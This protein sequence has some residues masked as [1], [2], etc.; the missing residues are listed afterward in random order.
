M[1]RIN[2]KDL[3]IVVERVMKSAR[4]AK[5]KNTVIDVIATGKTI[6]LKFGGSEL[7][8]SQKIQA[9]ITK[10]LNFS[11]TVM[12]LNLKVSALPNSELITVEEK[13][14]KIYFKWGRSSLVR[15]ERV[16]NQC[17]EMSFE[18]QGESFEWSYKSIQRITRFNMTSFTAINGTA[19]ANK[20]PQ[21]AGIYIQNKNNYTELHA[22]DS[23]KAISMVATDIKWFDEP[24]AIPT[25]TWFALYE[26]LSQD[27]I[28]SISSNGKSLVKFESES[29]VIISRIIVG[30]YPD[31]SA[32]FVQPEQTA[33]RWTIDRLE[34]LEATRRAR[35][36]ITTTGSTIELN[37]DGKKTYLI[38][39]DQLVQQIGAMIVGDIKKFI[40]NPEDLE[41]ILSILRTE[42]IVLSY[43]SLSSSM[44][45]CGI[46][47]E[48]SEDKTG[49]MNIKCMLTTMV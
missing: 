24:A 9:D 1:F 16:D 18:A 23:K 17:I 10:E 45:I 46:A 11:T 12:E 20:I 37:S 31:L 42:D 47:D 8:V 41:L 6:I 36:L 30:T 7:F 27:S 2:S 34:L 29:T 40:I 22:S 14:N 48:E 44:T 28:I 26:L 21:L 25:E 19:E 15:V 3:K 33:T 13:D 39:K 35:H 38:L 32:I 5:L 43:R 4:R 49:E